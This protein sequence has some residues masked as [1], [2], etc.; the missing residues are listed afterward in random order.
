[1]IIQQSLIELKEMVKQ[2]MI[3]PITYN[4]HYAID[5]MPEDNASVE[6]T[7]KRYLQKI[8]QQIQQ[9]F[10]ICWINTII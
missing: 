10:Q 1:M 2:M 5:I 9:H 4:G 8:Q 7:I 3:H 6:Q